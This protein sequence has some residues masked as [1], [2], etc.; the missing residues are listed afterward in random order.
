[1]EKHTIIQPVRFAADRMLGRLTRWLRMIGADV[2]SDP[3]IDG[4]AIL[5]RAR[6]EGRITITRDKRLRTASDVIWLASNGVAEQLREVFERHPQFSQIS[7]DANDRAF[8]RCVGCNTPLR[9]IAR[10]ALASRV[11]PFVYA[12]HRNFSCCDGCGK[13][14]WDATH[15]ARAIETLERIGVDT[16]RIRTGHVSA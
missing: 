15:R 8:T 4:A 12:S 9:S 2:I 16:Q 6:R 3:A 5:S 7:M 10:E 14:Y 1:M 11:P 13:I